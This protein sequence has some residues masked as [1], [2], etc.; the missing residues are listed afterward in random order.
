MLGTDCAYF[1]GMRIEKI[2]NPDTQPGPIALTE[3]QRL[4]LTAAIPFWRGVGE[5]TPMSTVAQETHEP[6]PSGTS[7]LKK[8]GKWHAD[9]DV[10][11]GEGTFDTD[12]LINGPLY[13][14]SLGN[15]SL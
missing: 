10:V 14:K 7:F 1:C 15:G 13:T 3:R 11:R 5:Q 6:I 9:H 4:E 12:I 8:K 2:Q